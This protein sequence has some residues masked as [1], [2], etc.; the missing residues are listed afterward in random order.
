MPLASIVFGIV[1][2]ALGAEGFTNALDLFH[3]QKQSMTA[4]IP[5]YFGAVLVLLGILA[6]KPNL[7]KHM[8]HVAAMIGLIG[9]AAGLGMG[10][11]SV[12][13]GN[14]AAAAKMQVAMGA[15][16]TVF[17]LLCI[18]SFIDARRRRALAQ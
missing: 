4:W 13:R 15:I 11:P 2:I 8:M 3:V 9:A 5:A 10:L 17:V 12:L 6:Y 16:C 14:A 18:K 7:R 1:L